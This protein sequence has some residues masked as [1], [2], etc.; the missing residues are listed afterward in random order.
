MGSQDFEPALF[1]L[2]DTR[3]LRLKYKNPSHPQA[4]SQNVGCGFGV[5]LFW[6]P[7]SGPKNATQKVKAN[8][9]PSLFASRFWVRKMALILGPLLGI[10]AIKKST[11]L[12]RNQDYT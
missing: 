11:L 12:R 4:S 1:Q 10:R 3:L 9:W 7:L 6:V 5:A 8:S 2:W